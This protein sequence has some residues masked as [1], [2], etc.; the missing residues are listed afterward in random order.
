MNA[1]NRP[2]TTSRNASAVAPS[3]PPDDADAKNA[4]SPCD[5]DHAT[6]RK[7]VKSS[8]TCCNTR[9]SPVTGFASNPNFDQSADVPAPDAVS[10]TAARREGG[11]D[12][13]GA[14]TEPP[15]NSP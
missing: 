2:E 8:T 5:T 6:S 13:G 9:G 4:S 10:P 11:V 1:S 12:E 15:V 3:N 7:Y 14:D